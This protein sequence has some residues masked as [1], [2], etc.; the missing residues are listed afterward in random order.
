MA[1]VKTK[2]GVRLGFNFGRFS[3][4]SFDH[5]LDSGSPQAPRGMMVLVGRRNNQNQLA[6]FFCIDLFEQCKYDSI[7]DLESYKRRDK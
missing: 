4:N 1:E 6:P 3:P 7:M 2:P 5:R